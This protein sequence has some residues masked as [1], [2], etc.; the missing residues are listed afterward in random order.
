MNPPFIETE[1]SFTPSNVTPEHLSPIEGQRNEGVTIAP[2]A[3]EEVSYDHHSQECL[4]ECHYL[5]GGTRHPGKII[6]TPGLTNI[7]P[8]RPTHRPHLPQRII[9]SGQLSEI[10]LER[11]IYAGQAHETRLPTSARP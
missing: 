4:Y 11:I 8:P 10:Q 5:K 3:G 7:R 2:T 6:E 1:N 9:E